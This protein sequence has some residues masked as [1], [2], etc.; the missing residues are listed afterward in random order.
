MAEDAGVKGRRTDEIVNA[1][2]ERGRTRHGSDRLI[3][4]AVWLCRPDMNEWLLMRASPAVFTQGH[5][6]EER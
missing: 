5:R 6:L 2:A 3:A 4:S 1:G